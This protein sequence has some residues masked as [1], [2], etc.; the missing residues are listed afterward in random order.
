MI[1]TYIFNS[2]DYDNVRVQIPLFC[3][4]MPDGTVLGT[5]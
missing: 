3:N 5:S 2:N 4:K 1:S